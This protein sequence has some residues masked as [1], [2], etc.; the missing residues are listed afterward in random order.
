MISKFEIKPNLRFNSIKSYHGIIPTHKF[1]QTKE[2]VKNLIK[3]SNNENQ[4]G[5]SPKVLMHLKESGAD[6]HFYP[7]D[8]GVNLKNALAKH[9]DINVNQI[10]LGAGSNQLLWL[11]AQTFV[12][13]ND[14][15]IIPQYSFFSYYYAAIAAGANPVIVPT[16]NWEYNAVDI[17]DAI[18]SNTKLIYIANPNNP[19]GSWMNQQSLKLF[20]QNVPSHILVI[21]DEAY[22]EYIDNSDFPD[23]LYLQKSFPNIIVT[24]TFSKAYGLAGLR[25]GYSI[26]DSNIALIL[27]N[28][29]DIFN[30]NSQALIAAQIALQDKDH[31]L[32]SRTLNQQGLEQ[33]KSGLRS[34][35]IKYVATIANFITIYLGEH[36]Q[37]I[38][39]KLLENGIIVCPLN[40]YDLSSYLRITIGTLEQNDF[41]LKTLALALQTVCYPS[42]NTHEFSKKFN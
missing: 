2:K 5:A 32:L 23:S 17:L 26:S 4:L 19:T 10:V 16:T 18:N 33:L 8:N 13:P 3:L 28:A 1:L 22:Y 39:Q 7:D 20:L 15:V 6:I 24:R 41:F 12:E 29:R 25:I 31:I 40:N 37:K 9:W 21:I 42:E 34:L 35:N 36:A 14:E 11:I 27:N 30:V 38:Y